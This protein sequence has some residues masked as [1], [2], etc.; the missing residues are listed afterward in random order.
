VVECMF[1]VMRV[2][3][4]VGVF[5]LAG[6]GCCCWRGRGG[7]FGENAVEQKMSR[8]WLRERLLYVRRVRTV[9]E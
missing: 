9:L 3:S 8:N 6:G 4:L 2:F 1:A 7:C 5:V